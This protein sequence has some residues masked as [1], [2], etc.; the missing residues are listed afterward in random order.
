MSDSLIF[1]ESIETPKQHDDRLRRNEYKFR[2]YFK[3]HESYELF[4]MLPLDENG[5]HV[6]LSAMHKEER[7]KLSK[8]EAENNET[9]DV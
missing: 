2:R 5:R 3:D 9:A 4:M 1:G 8:R 7:S 6:L